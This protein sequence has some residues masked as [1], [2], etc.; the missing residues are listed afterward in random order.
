MMGGNDCSN[1]VPAG[2]LF[3]EA[4]TT[5]RVLEIAKATPHW[6]SETAEGRASV[7]RA[8]LGTID[9]PGLPA[10]LNAPIWPQL[11]GSLQVDL[12]GPAA[13]NWLLALALGTDLVTIPGLGF[14]FLS[15]PSVIVGVGGLGPAGLGSFSMPV[16]TT[17]SLTGLELFAQGLTGGCLTNLLRVVV[18]P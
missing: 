17:P 8:V 12:Q 1:A 3:Y 13:G 4:V 18:L 15:S 16:P 7:L 5:H 2:L 9:C 6:T 10:T 11:G 14:L